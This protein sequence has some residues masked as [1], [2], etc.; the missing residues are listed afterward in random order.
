MRTVLLL[1]LAWS[2]AWPA[3][4]QATRTPAPQARKA[5]PQPAQT[6][7]QIEAAVRARFARSKIGQNN[8]QVRVQGGVATLEGKTEVMQHKGTATRL[9][10][11]AGAAGVVNKIEISQAARDRAAANLSTGRRRAQVKRSEEPRGSR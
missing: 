3:A 2:A 4:A 7:A 5:R 10:K 9:A 11:G 1:L 6:D 8:F